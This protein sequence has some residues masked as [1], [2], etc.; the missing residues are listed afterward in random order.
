MLTKC[1][2]CKAEWSTPMG[3]TVTVCP[4]CG[5]PVFDDKNID[6]DTQLHELFAR[7]VKQKG[8]SILGDRVL[9]GILSDLMP[10]LERK[11]HNVIGRALDD[12]IGQQLLEIVNEEEAVRN[13][14]V[15]NIKKTFKTKN[16]FDNTAN[17]VIDCFLYALKLIEEPET[18]EK[19]QNNNN[20]K[21][22]VKQVE[23]AFV[24]GVLI[25]RDAISLFEYAHSIGIP[26]DTLS[27]MIEKKIK[28]LKLY[29][30]VPEDF[31][32]DVVHTDI[33]KGTRKYK[34]ISSDWFGIAILK[35]LDPMFE[36]AARLVVKVQLGSTSLVQRRLSIGYKRA[37][38]IIDQLEAAGIVGP[39][40]GSK[41]R[42]VLVPD[43]T[44][45]EEILKSLDL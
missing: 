4:F 42:E 7:I 6:K 10:T 19:Q 5:E 35:E 21:L 24:D 12:R 39:F 30:F 36:E 41:A 18:L 8:I 37:G 11:Y 29:P 34:I 40:E 26:D 20:I 14:R 1:I 45:L 9:K 3:N 32:S 2:K 38:Q 27:D 22:L 23:E 44:A 31:E 25:N 15:I 28:E 33:D 16:G 43:I 17:Y 13:L